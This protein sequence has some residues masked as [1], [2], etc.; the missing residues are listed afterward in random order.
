MGKIHTASLVK[1]FVGILYSMPDLLGEVENHLEALLGPIDLRSEAFPF[2]ATHYYDDEMGSPLERRFLL[3]NRL[4]RAENIAA[5]KTSTN[6]LEALLAGKASNVQR[7]VNLDPGYLELAKIVLASSKNFYHRIL[8]ADG[9]YAEVTQH[10]ESQEWRS[11][12]WT[13]PDF[14]DG[15]YNV[16]FSNARTIYREQLKSLKRRS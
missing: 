5:I 4:I 11:F 7:P 8:I 10:F 16:F 12:P 13:F 9:I 2:D 6:R 14:R 1:P 15:R 3:F